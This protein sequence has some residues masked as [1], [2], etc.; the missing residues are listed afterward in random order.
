MEL[1]VKVDKLSTR[2]SL[3]MSTHDEPSISANDATIKDMEQWCDS[4]SAPQA[5]AE[6]Q[7]NG[8]NG[9]QVPDIHGVRNSR[10]NLGHAITKMRKKLQRLSCIGYCASS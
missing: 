2:D 3:D 6:A 7:H 5:G 1:N 8:F 10:H 9:T 4:I